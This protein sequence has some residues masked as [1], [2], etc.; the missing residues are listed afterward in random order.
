VTAKPSWEGNLPL[1]ESIYLA[2]LKWHM[3]TDD[4]VQKIRNDSKAAG[5]VC[6]PP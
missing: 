2:A 3:Q 5:H 4:A 6:L 1:P